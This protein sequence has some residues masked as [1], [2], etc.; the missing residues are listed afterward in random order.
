[1]AFIEKRNGAWRVSVC[2]KGIRKTATFDTKTECKDW[3][4]QI[5]ADILNNNFIDK[6]LLDR[7]EISLIEIFDKYSREVSFKKKGGSQEFIRLK[8]FSKEEIF[9]QPIDQ[10]T[11]RLLAEWRDKRLKVV[12]GSTVNRDLNLL[13]DIFTMAIKEW[14]V[15][16]PNNPVHM[17]QRP[18][19]PAARERTISE[20]EKRKIAKVLDW[21]MGSSPKTTKQWV[22]F[23]FFLAIET[24]MRRGEILSLQWENVHLEES[25]LHL[26]STKN[27]EKR[28]VPLSLRA[29]KLL[30]LLKVGKANDNIVPLTPYNLSRAFNK[31]TKIAQIKDLH[32]HDARREATTQLSKKLSNVL[33]LS[34]VTGHKDLQV[35]KR[36]YKPKASDLAKK[37]N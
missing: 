6:K 8:F 15:N 23:A 17:I 36:Y 5:E 25:Y 27:G 35:L 26:E 13:S 1:M 33:E 37:L 22:A 12:K 29:K 20:E 28:D 31:A 11:P 19:N 10:I 16:I 32:F 24:A 30:S 34:A 7:K 2:R 4:S 9:N 21:D 14:G 3:A 18:K